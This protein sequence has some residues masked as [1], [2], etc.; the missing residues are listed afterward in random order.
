MLDPASTPALH[1]T[2]LTMQATL[3][4]YDP[5]QH[6]QGYTHKFLG[7]LYTDENDFVCLYTSV[8]AKPYDTDPFVYCSLLMQ[9]TN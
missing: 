8:I 1:L 7:F 3:G 6:G 9:R 5:E 2:A 4:Q